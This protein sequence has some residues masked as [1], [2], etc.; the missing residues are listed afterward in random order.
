ME[1]LNNLKNQI[2]EKSNLIKDN[3]YI[4][5]LSPQAHEVWIEGEVREIRWNSFGIDKVRIALAI[6]G[7][8]KGHL[9]D[10]RNNFIIDAKQ[11]KYTWKISPGFVTNFGITRSDEV[12]I[13]FFNASN[14]QTLGKCIF[15]IQGTD[16]KD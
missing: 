9:G 2:A 1:P 4:K 11:K 14:D 15:T 16:S 5:I 6:G 7:H 12:Q 8:D 10:E 3:P 13:A